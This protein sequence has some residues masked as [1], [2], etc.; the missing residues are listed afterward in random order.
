MF[1]LVTPDATSDET[2]IN[3]IAADPSS[4]FLRVVGAG[5][6]RRANGP[7][8]PPR[9]FASNHRRCRI[10]STVNATS[11]RGGL[12]PNQECANPLVSHR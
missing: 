2:S 4:R 10:E 3:R 11:R 5:R 12:P 7:T 1:Q 6:P 8:S 9:L